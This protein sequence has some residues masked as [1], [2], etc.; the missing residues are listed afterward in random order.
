MLRPGTTSFYLRSTDWILPVGHS[1][2][3]EI[4]TIQPG[5]GPDNDWIDTPSYERIIV[6]DARL[7]LALDNP[8]DDTHTPGD[9]APWL[10]TY[11][12]GYTE[13]LSLGAPAFTVPTG[14]R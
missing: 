14:G 6:H 12:L 11:R 13:K 9:R 5:F 2:A 7:E 10:D 8:G 4:G 3:V 1:L